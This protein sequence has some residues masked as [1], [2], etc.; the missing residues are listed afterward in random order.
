MLNNITYLGYALTW[1]GIKP[2]M[3]K[4]QGIMYIGQYTTTTA[5][6]YIIGILQ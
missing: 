5:A 4:V 2:D 3:D 1:D 6:W